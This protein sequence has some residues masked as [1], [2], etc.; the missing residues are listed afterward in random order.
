MLPPYI[1]EQI[2]K[3]E[4]EKHRRERWPRVEMPMEQPPPDEGGWPPNHDPSH[5]DEGSVE[6]DYQI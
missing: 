5:E 4:E 6:V 1:I 3:R 2:R